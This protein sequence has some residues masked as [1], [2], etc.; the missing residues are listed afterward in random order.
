M[1]KLDV[2]QLMQ[3]LIDVLKETK[4]SNK[5]LDSFDIHRTCQLFFPQIKDHVNV[6]PHRK[7]ILELFVQTGDET[8]TQSFLEHTCESEIYG[9]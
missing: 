4:S 7:A 8:L 6:M 9:I 1:T 5:H 2:Q 3:L